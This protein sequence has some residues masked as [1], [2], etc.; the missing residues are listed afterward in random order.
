MSEQG[1]QGKRHGHHIIP[2]KV[3]YLVFGGL[4]FLTITTVITASFELGLLSVPVA[5]AIA[6]VKAGLVVMFFM[7]LKYDSRVNLLVFTI[8]L[9]FV[10]VFLGFTL[11]DTEFRGMFDK[12]KASTI[13]EQQ[14]EMDERQKRSD[15]VDALIAK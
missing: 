1:S 10:A 8:G 3:Y 9:F 13:S 6:I 4:I 12:T 2:Y 5:L 15:Q 14:R 7:A 11:L